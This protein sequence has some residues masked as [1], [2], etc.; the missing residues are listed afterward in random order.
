V[1]RAERRARDQPLDGGD[2]AIEELDMAQRALQRLGLLEWQ[3][4][5]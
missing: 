2:L 1:R 3:L 5:L 4:E